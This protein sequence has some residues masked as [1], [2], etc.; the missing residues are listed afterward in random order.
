M[1]ANVGNGQ[2][3]LI[4]KTKRKAQKKILSK[5]VSFPKHTTLTTNNLYLFLPF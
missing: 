4:T 1:W 5:I 2:K 3:M